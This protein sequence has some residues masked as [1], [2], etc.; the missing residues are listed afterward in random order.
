[1]MTGLSSCN[2]VAD[3]FFIVAVTA[4]VIISTGQ[5]A[6]VE[7]ALLGESVGLAVE[8]VLLVNVIITR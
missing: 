7:V 1:M 2:D 8:R 3:S 5:G 4:V 6:I